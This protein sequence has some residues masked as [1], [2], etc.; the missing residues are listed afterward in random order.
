[1]SI[2]LL[3]D[4]HLGSPLS[5]CDKEIINLINNPKF[6]LIYIVGDLIDEWEA[7]PIKIVGDHQ[8]LIDTIKNSPDRVKIVMGNHDPDIVFMS[9]LFEGNGVADHFS[10]EGIMIIHGHQF[11]YMVKNYEWMYRLVFPIH[12]VLERLGIN[13][14]GFLA[15]VIHSIAA[16]KQKKYYDDLVMAIEKEAVKEYGMFQHVVMGHTHLGK[17]ADGD[18]TYVNCGSM[19]HDKTYV[20]YDEGVFYLKGVK[21]NVV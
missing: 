18:T 13:V 11:D 7:N 5:D 2:L 15:E 17:I 19:T 8:D 21:D 12:W 14:K 1:M 4:L 16:K 3:S 9:S 20:E 10:V 6:E